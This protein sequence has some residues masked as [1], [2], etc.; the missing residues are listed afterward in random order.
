MQERLLITMKE[1]PNVILR[2]IPGH[3]I[4]PHAH[5]NYY[6]DMTA[7]KSRTHEAR[8][9]AAELAKKGIEIDRKRIIMKDIKT[10]G[11]YAATVIFHKEVKV[12][13]P[14]TVIAEG[15]EAPAV[16]AAP[17]TETVATEEVSATETAE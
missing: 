5:S 9:A 10:V 2:A 17:A 11:E 1:N 8:A 3:F 14:V 16:E 7:I 6:L 15:K 13:I 4:T 12:E